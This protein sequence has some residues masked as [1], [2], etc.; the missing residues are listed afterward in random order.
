MGRKAGMAMMTPVAN[1]RNICMTCVM[2]TRSWDVSVISGSKPRYGQNTAV[3]PNQNSIWNV[4][5][6][7]IIAVLPGANGGI[8]MSRKNTHIGRP[9]NIRNG[10]RRPHRL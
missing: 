2:I 7:T 6:H 5:T 3:T 4:A 8:H 10:I 9:P 1:N